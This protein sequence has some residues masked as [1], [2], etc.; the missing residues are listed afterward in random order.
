LP[1]RSEVQ[2][3]LVKALCAETGYPAELIDPKADLEADLG[4][5]TV[6]QAQTLG[7]VRD[8]FDIR[9]D[10]RLSLRDF[11]TL[12]HILDY[13]ERELAKKAAR[14]A[15]EP[16]PKPS[17]VAVVDVTEKRGATKL[18][19][20]AAK[21][22][23]NAAP[24]R[25]VPAR[26]APAPTVAQAIDGVPVIATSAPTPVAAPPPARGL[27]VEPVRE[28]SGPVALPTVFLHLHGTSRELGEQHGEAL[29]EQIREVM[30]RYEAFIGVRGGELLELPTAISH[31]VSLFDPPSIEEL[32]GVARA[33]GVPFRHLLAYN[34]DAALFPAFVS[35]CTQAVRLAWANDGTMLHFVNEDSPLLLHLGGYTPRAVQ[36]RRRTDGPHPHRRVVAFNVAG[37][38][39]G[40]NAVNDAG[41]T[42]T[43]TTLLDGP[44]RDGIPRGA[45]HPYL[46]KRIAEEASSLPEAVAITR[47]FP[48]TGRWS[49]LVSDAE[50]DEAVYVEYDDATILREEYVTRGMVTTN[51][52][53]SGAAPGCFAPDHS[54]HRAARAESLVAAEKPLTVERAKELLRDREDLGRGRAVAHP[55]MNT[56]RRVDNVMSLVV[57]PKARRFHVTDRVV[58]PGAAA[59]DTDP[60]QYVTLGYGASTI[61]TRHSAIASRLVRDSALPHPEAVSQGPGGEVKS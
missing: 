21:P 32:E 5:D 54:L 61:A 55:T 26:T 12:D 45:P 36:L 60:V 43:S 18:P 23:A 25:A 6:K 2:A 1:E 10:E 42:I 14:A 8:H 47:D 16:A 35:G 33:A 49:V 30:D 19:A 37:Q 52:A 53:L 20:P 31:V 28:A 59:A 57:E 22:A 48:R 29:R 13:V 24:E 15:T 46:V 17:R 27:W 3:F 41:L 11:P 34:L 44:A 50:R 56:V 58:P 9:T 51:H 39:A 4:I 40:P 7:K 38:V